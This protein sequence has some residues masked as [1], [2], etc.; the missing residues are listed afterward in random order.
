MGYR[1]CEVYCPRAI[2]RLFIPGS[3]IPDLEKAQDLFCEVFGQDAP[4][5]VMSNCIWEKGGSTPSCSWKVVLPPNGTRA[6][7]E[8]FVDS[9]YKNQQAIV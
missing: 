6:M 4:R 8:S 1:G 5:I 3:L 2:P 7:L 9:L